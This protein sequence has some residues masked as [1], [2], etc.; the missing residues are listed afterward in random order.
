MR[1]IVDG[2]GIQID[3]SDLHFLSL[4]SWRVQQQ[5]SKRYVRASTTRKGKRVTIYL[6]RLITDAGKG[7]IVDHMDGDTMNNQRSNFRLGDHK[8]NARNAC[9]IMARTTSS[10]FRGVMLRK[11]KWAARI[12][13]GVK[14]SAIELG[15]FSRE[16]EAAYAYD[17][18]SLRIH[19]EHGRRNF[20][21]LVF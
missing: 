13:D 5:G 14:K 2:V 8:I 4:Y 7:V 19:G 21:P 6:H 1:A 17:M 15:Q 20:L 12:R 9:K 16:E 11:G 10:R 3:E 18:A